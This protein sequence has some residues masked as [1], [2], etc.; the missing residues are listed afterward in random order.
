MRARAGCPR[1]LAR[2]LVHD[3]GA[4]V[5]RTV[6]GRNQNAAGYSENVLR[7]WL[8]YHR[9][10]R[11]RWRSGRAGS[12][13]GVDARARATEAAA[14][15]RPEGAHIAQAR[16]QAHAAFRVAR[17]RMRARAV[18]VLEHGLPAH[19]RR[20]QAAIGMAIGAARQAR[21]AEGGDVGR[22]RIERCIEPRR[23]GPGGFWVEANCASVRK[24]LC[25]RTGGC[26]SRNPRSRRSSRSS[27]PGR[28]PCRPRR[29]GW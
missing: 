3:P 9:G 7:G 25:R 6:L 20:A 27:A 10:S 18:L 2:E 12:S 11:A 19:R 24:P 13:R 14:G 21:R 8:R 1:R 29:A 26:R 16:R 17:G 5:R 4:A 22:K 23:G 28:A 15:G